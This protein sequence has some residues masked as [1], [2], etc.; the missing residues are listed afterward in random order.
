MSK[1]NLLD[2]GE[3][4]DVR[5][6]KES[7]NSIVLTWQISFEHIRQTRSS[8]ADLLSLM[9]MF[10][11]QAIPESLLRNR[12]SISGSG[13]H[14]ITKF[15]RFAKKAA[16]IFGKQPR[17]AASG[18]VF[19]DQLEED[20]AFLRCYSFVAVT[21]DDATFKMHHLVQLATRKWLEDRGQLEIWKNQSV[22]NLCLEISLP[23]KQPHSQVTTFRFS[24]ALYPHIYSVMRTR[25][26][27]KMCLE[28]TLDS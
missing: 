1:L 7:S 12:P 19:N 10:D 23:E 2:R 6:D 5:R 28:I 22:Q 4:A 17:S 9:S 20:V 27:P 15:R 8:A 18:L 26:T 13:Q 14:P 16:R 24:P 11:R 25:P 21:T 3:G